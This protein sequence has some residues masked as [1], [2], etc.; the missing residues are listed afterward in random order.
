MTTA[1]LAA[2]SEAALAAGRIIR[3]CHGRAHRVEDAPAHDLK[4]ELDRV[5]ESEIV[6][7]IR[8]AF[9]AYAM[10]SEEMGYVPGRE[11]CLW[12]VDP[13]DGTVNCYHGVPFFC[14]SIA[15]YTTREG[16]GGDPG[17]RLPDG[18]ILGDPLVGVVY[19]PLR[20]EL[21]TGVA[22]AEASLNRAVLPVPCAGRLDQT[23]VALSFGAREESIA[24]MSRLFPVMAKAAR[25]VRSFGCTALDI[26]Q[27]AAGRIGAFVQMGTNLWDFAAGAVVA[28]AAGAVVDAHEYQPGRWRI[29]ASAAGIFE[30]V[31]ARAEG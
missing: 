16:T 6:R 29:I 14:T 19:D 4:L 5:C 18:R 21:F 7:I 9:P 27:V 2:A 31:R 30:D 8:A 11:P 15:C 23:M 12:I 25:K 22:G 28:R 3:D 24:Y 13:L 26:A 10:L 17:S 20:D 1:L